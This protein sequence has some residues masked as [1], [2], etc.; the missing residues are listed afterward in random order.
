MSSRNLIRDRFLGAAAGGYYLE[1]SVLARGLQRGHI[2]TGCRM[3]E[4]QNVAPDPAP[5]PAFF[6][7]TE[8]GEGGRGA[9]NV[10]V[11]VSGMPERGVAQCAVWAGDGS[12]RIPMMERANQIPAFDS[13]R[14]QVR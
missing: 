6:K 2:H 13:V 9:D 8:D 7:A 14:I 5:V 1:A 12:H 3:L 4:S 11:E 10:T